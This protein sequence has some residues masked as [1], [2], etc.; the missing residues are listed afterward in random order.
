MEAELE[1][2]NSYL[3]GEVFGYIIT[4]VMGKGQAPL[5]ECSDTCWGFMGEIDYCISDAK[6]QIDC[7]L[8]QIEEIK[9]AIN[10]Q[11]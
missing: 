7:H 2:Y 3:T 9:N 5:E 10:F 1:T 6:S 11:I 4:P 8:K